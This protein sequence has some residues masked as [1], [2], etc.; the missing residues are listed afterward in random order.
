MTTAPQIRVMGKRV[1]LEKESFF[2]P[3][4]MRRD[5][6]HSCL[7]FSQLH[8]VIH[9]VHWCSATWQLADCD[10]CDRH[11][12]MVTL[13]IGFTV[14]TDPPG[15][16][17]CDNCASDPGKFRIPESGGGGGPREMENG[18]KVLHRIFLFFETE[19]HVHIVKLALA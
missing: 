19:H 12:H 13:C 2:T 15:C 16:G 1:K 4:R 9:F 5:N 17:D 7:F 10:N 8:I 11:G 6:C 18:S 3:P 14:T